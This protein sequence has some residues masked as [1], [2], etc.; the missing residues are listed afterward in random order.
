LALPEP[1]PGMASPRVNAVILGVAACAVSLCFF[2]ISALAM[3]PTATGGTA[4]LDGD[5][6]VL[7]FSAAHWDSTRLPQD[8]RHS[9]DQHHI[10]E[11][12][13]DA[14]RALDMIGGTTA[15]PA[16][17]WLQPASGNG[18][19][20][21]SGR[22]MAGELSDDRASALRRQSFRLAL[23][24]CKE[25]SDCETLLGKTMYN[26]LQT[27]D[28]KPNLAI[29]H[30]QDD[31]RKHEER[32]IEHDYRS[33]AERDH[34]TSQS[35]QRWKQLQGMMHLSFK[36]SA[37]TARSVMHKVDVIEKE[38]IPT[39]EKRILV[40]ALM[41]KSRV[42]R[43][44]ASLNDSYRSETSLIFAGSSSSN[45]HW[46][47]YRASMVPSGN[48]EAEEMGEEMHRRA[49]PSEF[50]VLRHYQTEALGGGK[51]SKG[52]RAKSARSND[53]KRDE[54]SDEASQAARRQVEHWTKVAS[55]LR[56]R[57]GKSKQG[58]AEAEAEQRAKMME[59]ARDQEVD[60][61]TAETA[62]D[63]LS[64]YERVVGKGP[65]GHAG[66]VRRAE[67][68]AR[69]AVLRMRQSKLERARA[70]EQVKLVNEE[71]K[72][73]KDADDEL[74]SYD[75]AFVPLADRDALV[76][77]ASL[78]RLGLVPP[79]SSS[80]SSASAHGRRSR[81]SK[82]MAGRRQRRHFRAPQQR[83]GSSSR[84]ES[85]RVRSG[86]R[87][88]R[89]RERESRREEGRR[90]W[91]RGRRVQARGRLRTE[92]EE[93]GGG[94]Q[95]ERGGERRAQLTQLAEHPSLRGH[96]ASLQHAEE[97]AWA[98]GAGS[99]VGKEAR[100]GGSRCYVAGGRE[101]DCAEVTELG[102]L[103]NKVYGPKAGDV[104]LRAKDGRFDPT[105]VFTSSR[106]ARREGGGETESGRRSA[107][108]VGGGG[109][110]E[111]GSGGQKKAEGGA[112]RK[113]ELEGAHGDELPRQGKAGRYAERGHGETLGDE[114]HEENVK[115]AEA[116]TKYYE[117]RKGPLEKLSDKLKNVLGW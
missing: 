69:R 115:A 86:V 47:T 78:A 106:A 89:G 109:R 66:E 90:S 6:N 24:D 103:L 104:E 37:P 50:A 76:S 42:A 35:K 5:P 83:M 36:A 15:G 52:G 79:S 53:G 57:E 74:A 27:R 48:D 19:L 55:R 25:Q 43:R 28:G 116:E 64:R 68:A 102:A 70:I 3:P 45:E 12:I 34:G 110:E 17:H 60:K 101:V 8:R 2:L 82:V 73:A 33:S 65:H 44:A 31:D 99:V 16:R 77:S 62:D 93:K 56:R 63:E 46:N 105:Q 20:T 112:Q 114:L 108:R 100:G 29:Y 113:A 9:H 117:V 85:V 59:H 94:G 39:D 61:E 96:A 58:A 49:R 80:R 91:G 51:E 98:P 30:D 40:Q 84:E 38:H 67:R 21:A 111:E 97:S 92:K 75:Q 87:G 14:V 81:R 26:V 32:I 11:K 22:N 4:L 13:N 1:V 71:A 72:E 10:G 18:A 54:G 7:T 23:H 95:E 88:G 107:S 41:R